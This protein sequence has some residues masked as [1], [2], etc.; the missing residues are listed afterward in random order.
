MHRDRVVLS[1]PTPRPLEI[2]AHNR[3][4]CGQRTTTSDVTWYTTPSGAGVFSSGTIDWVCSIT[5]AHCA[6]GGGRTSSVVRQVT[7]NLL[8]QIAAGPAGRTHPA[9]DNVVRVLGPLTGSR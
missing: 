8:R 2:L 6:G 1:D 3:F 9:V 7:A 4:R 5:G